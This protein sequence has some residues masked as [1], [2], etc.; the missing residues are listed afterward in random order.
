MMWALVTGGN[1]SVAVEGVPTSRSSF[2]SSMIAGMLWDVV[3]EVEVEVNVCS[4]G[5]FNHS[6]SRDDSTFMC[7]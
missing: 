6:K 7:N 5:G 3:R 1:G 2:S 4:G